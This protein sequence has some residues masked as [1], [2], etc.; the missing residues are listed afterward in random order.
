M[1][2]SSPFHSSFNNFLLRSGCALASLDISLPEPQLWRI[3]RTA[4][5]SELHELKLSR[6]AYPFERPIFLLGTSFEAYFLKYRSE[7]LNN[8]REGSS[9]DADFMFGSKEASPTW[10]AVIKVQRSTLMTVASHDDALQADHALAVEHGTMPAVPLSC[11]PGDVLALNSKF[12]EW[13]FDSHNHR[14]LTLRLHPLVKDNMKILLQ[15]WLTLGLGAYSHASKASCHDHSPSAMARSEN[16]RQA[17][18][19]AA[20]RV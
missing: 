16:G 17:C 15:H 2:A 3:A 19:A 10:N 11:V 6:D 9:S 8:C 13:K 1:A 4:P 20:L 12:F 18:S 14:S 5:L 7:R